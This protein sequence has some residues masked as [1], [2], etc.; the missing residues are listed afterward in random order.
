[1][2]EK[3]C[4]GQR[5]KFDP[6][7]GFFKELFNRKML[8]DIIPNPTRPS[9]RNGRVEVVRIAKILDRFFVQSYLIER[10]NQL[11]TYSFYIDIFDHD[12]II[13]EWSSSNELKALPFKFNHMWL[14][15]PKFLEL[16]RESWAQH[17]ES[18]LDKKMEKVSFKL[19]ILKKVA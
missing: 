14:R 13:L 10:L 7:A 12:M 5:A 8:N 3:E 4:W 6:M 18:Y 11:K 1:M 2:E 15:E 17:L 9:W 16:V 19:R